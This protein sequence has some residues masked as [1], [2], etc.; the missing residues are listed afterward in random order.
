LSSQKQGI[1]DFN[2]FIH[3]G[4]SPVV[5]SCGLLPL[6]HLPKNFHLRVIVPLHK[7]ADKSVIANYRPITLLNKDYRLL[8]AILGILAITGK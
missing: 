6:G 8:A 1:K 3:C 4:T 5:R 7:K 2:N